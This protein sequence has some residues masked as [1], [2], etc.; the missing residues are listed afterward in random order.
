MPC[1]LAFRSYHRGL[2]TDIIISFT[3]CWIMQQFIL[4]MAVSALGNDAGI[5][6]HTSPRFYHRGVQIGIIV[7]IA[8][9][10]DSAIIYFVITDV[11]FKKIYERL[12]TY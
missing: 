9:E 6:R 8:L 11:S 4:L 7:R 12:R 2:R 3:L 10:L 5:L 1:T